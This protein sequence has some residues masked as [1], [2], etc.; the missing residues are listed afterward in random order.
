M[1]AS[2]VK[3][4][5]KW[6]LERCEREGDHLLWKGAVNEGSPRGHVPGSGH[7]ASN[8][9]FSVR[10]AAFTLWNGRPVAPGMRAHPSCGDPLCLAK[11]C[12][13]ERPAG[14]YNK[15]KPRSAV[16]RRRIAESQRAQLGH[17]P[18]VVR[19]IRDADTAMQAVKELGV[20]RSSAYDIRSGRR[21]RDFGGG[22][23]HIAATLS[24]TAK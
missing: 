9:Q 3:I 8:Q 7:K 24:H 10:L 13:Q 17:P 20:K 16:T 4:T 11:A 12:L 1:K 14:G 15:G 23:G 5:R 18:E 6:L 21:Q 2:D 22:I 19:A